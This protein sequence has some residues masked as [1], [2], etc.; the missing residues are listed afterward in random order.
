MDVST[1]I[2]CGYNDMAFI[3]EEGMAKEERT[4]IAGYSA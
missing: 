2:L 1:V 4:W 3:V